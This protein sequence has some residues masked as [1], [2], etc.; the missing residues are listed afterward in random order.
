MRKMIPVIVRCVLVNGVLSAAEFNPEADVSIRLSSPDSRNSRTPLY[1]RSLVKENS[2]R[3][4]MSYIRFNI[5][6]TKG[7]VSNAVFTL[8]TH[9]SHKSRWMRG[10]VEV[11]GLLDVEGNTPQRWNE[12]RLSYNSSGAEVIKPMPILQDRRDKDRLVFLGAFEAGSNEPDQSYSFSSSELDSFLTG[13]L[14]NSGLVTLLVCNRYDSNR[15][16]V[17]HSREADNKVWRPRLEF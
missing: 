14:E 9:S 8:T 16:L 5:G 11:Y 2:E 1:A 15:E 10:H 6:T 17:F 13:R 12:D 3:E 4:D 7:P